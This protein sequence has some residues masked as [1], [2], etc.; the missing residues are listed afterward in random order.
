MLKKFFLYFFIRNAFF[1]EQDLVELVENTDT[2]IILNSLNNTLT[3]YSLPAN[4][5]RV[6]NVLTY[7]GSPIYLSNGFFF[8][9]LQFRD[10]VDDSFDFVYSNVYGESIRFSLLLRSGFQNQLLARTCN[11]NSDF[12]QNESSVSID[13]K[14]ANGGFFR[15]SVELQITQLSDYRS[16][17]TTVSN[18][19]N[20]KPNTIYKFLV[21]LN[22]VPQEDFQKTF[23]QRFNF[24]NLEFKMNSNQ[25]NFVA[26]TNSAFNYT[27]CPQ[28]C[29]VCDSN[30]V[31]SECNGGFSL[32]NKT[33]SCFCRLNITSYLAVQN[34]TFLIGG[35]ERF[36]YEKQNICH[37]PITRFDDCIQEIRN[38]DQP[39]FFNM[40]TNSTFNSQ[41]MISIGVNYTQ[42]SNFNGIDQACVSKMMIY[43][44]VPFEKNSNLSLLLSDPIPLSLSQNQILNFTGIDTCMSKI[45]S[46]FGFS[47]IICPIHSS[48]QFVDP[49]FTKTI[50][51]RKNRHI[52]IS[53]LATGSLSLNYLTIDYIPLE[54]YNATTTIWCSAIICNDASCLK[55]S[56]NAV[57]P[58][59]QI[60]YVV[61]SI[62]DPLFLQ[63]S[64]QVYPNLLANQRKRNSLLLSTFQ[65]RK[66]EFIFA[67]SLDSKELFNTTTFALLLSYGIGGEGVYNNTEVVTFS[68]I[69]QNS[70]LLF[71]LNPPFWETLSFYWLVVS[72]GFL[73]V[74]AIFGL[75]SFSISFCLKKEPKKINSVLA[76][77][78]EGVSNRFL[79]LEMQES[80]NYVNVGKYLS[81]DVKK[82]VQTDVKGILE[83]LMR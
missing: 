70:G 60:L 36:V 13:C 45:Y 10:V 22:Y 56:S 20:L 1:F 79:E 29:K 38:L 73:P 47:A 66:N 17:W 71:P 9:F 54:F 18:Q 49:L 5:R 80:G 41:T 26:I 48:F 16:P 2:N 67:I 19:L 63:N 40:Y 53:D 46:E 3:F 65:R 21:F 28:F 14:N 15:V 42:V 12:L 81:S 55:F 58:N 61:V 23:E 44:S 50:F 68:V 75:C 31:C 57:F 27:K 74:A 76:N 78:N 52:S 35:E 77:K 37:T 34:G 51:Q 8:Y 43:F 69:I 25:N 11:Q 72:L 24:L 32:N 64:L 4:Y 39:L 62:S 83:K 7:S 33:N 30:G 6:L 59:S 82:P